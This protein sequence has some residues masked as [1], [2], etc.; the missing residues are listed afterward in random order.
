M[1]SSLT[2][3]QQKQVDA[4]ITVGSNLYLHTIPGAED[5]PA[6]LEFSLPDSRYRYLLFCLSTAVTAALAYDEGKGIEPDML[7]RGC[8]DFATWTAAN[9]PQEYFGVAAGPPT[10]RQDGMTHFTEFLRHWSTWPALEKDGQMKATR[11]LI[12][13]MIH[14]TESTAPASTADKTRL[15]KLALEIDCRLPTMRGAFVELISR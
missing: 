9:S 6:P 12:G 7:C 8:L 1:T 11:E 3:A 15:A 10:A 2:P 13:S 14:T 5:A 4:A